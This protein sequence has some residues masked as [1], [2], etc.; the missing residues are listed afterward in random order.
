MKHRFSQIGVRDV[1]AGIYAQR[2]E[3]ERLKYEGHE[4]RKQAGARGAMQNL[5]QRH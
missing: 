3:F 2:D 4:G 1:C 5:T